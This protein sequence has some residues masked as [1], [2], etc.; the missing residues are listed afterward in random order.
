MSRRPSPDA[1]ALA[2][3]AALVLASLA[4]R[5]AYLRSIPGLTGFDG[6]FYAVQARSLL[7]GG[8]LAYGAPSLAY[9]PI[10]AA[11]AVAGDPV[12]GVEIAAALGGA[13]LAIP[14]YGLGREATGSRPLAIA[15]AALGLRSDVL[16]FHS[17][18]FLR[19][20][21]GLIPYAAFLASSIRWARTEGREGRAGVLVGGLAAAACHPAVAGLVAVQGL[22]TGAL[23]TGQRRGLRIPLVAAGLAALAVLPLLDRLAGGLAGEPRLAVA[24]ALARHG[25][26]YGVTRLVE[27]GVLPLVAVAGL[28]ALG[29]G[30]VRPRDRGPVLAGVLG[31]A[32]LLQ[33]WWDAGPEG[34][35]LR[36][37]RIA[38][39]PALGLGA[40]LL[41]SPEPAGPAPRRAVGAVLV[42]LVC[43]VTRPLA[44]GIPF[45]E[46][47]PDYE[48]GRAAVETLG[49]T[50]PPGSRV[51]AP[52]GWQFFVT[53]ETGLPAARRPPAG[54]PSWVLHDARAE[55]PF[56]GVAAS[57]CPGEPAPRDLGDGFQLLA[58]PLWRCLERA[59][60]PVLPGPT[61]RPGRGRGYSQGP[62]RPRPVAEADAES[63]RSYR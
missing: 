37:A 9:L 50:L 34:L 11:V 49:R 7:E 13:L 42:L 53:H 39:V 20:S 48:R 5:L 14:L 1:L 2:V 28:L 54:E 45:A 4:W 43:V 32:V 22:A 8:R 47:R 58:D 29:T 38:T 23:G 3:L 44:A 33:P 35:A 19:A 60:Y 55:E 26:A 24:V 59:G 40:L 61:F 15:L 18:D 46:G 31:L 12:L 25:T 16:L 62:L 10:A 30:R 63:R 36:L 56:D 21:W 17:L 6:Y 52:H 51:V 41:S 57:L 27:L